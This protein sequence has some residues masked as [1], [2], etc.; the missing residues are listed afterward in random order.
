VK[1]ML[2]QVVFIV[3]SAVL[4]MIAMK[5]HAFEM[6]VEFSAD[7]IQ[8]L[9][10][11]TLNKSKMFVSKTAV[12]TETKQQGRDVVEIN[13]LLTGKKILLDTEK[14]VYREKQGVVMRPAWRDKK[15]RSPC[16]G[17]KGIKCL[18]LGNENL[19]NMVVKKWQVERIINGKKF[20]SM[21]WIESDRRFAIKEMMP[22]G[23]IAELILI[24]SGKLDG[25]E[26]EQWKSIYS[27]PSGQSSETRQWYDKELKMV[28]R[29][30]D[31]NG[32]VR[33]LVNIKVERQSP[34]L[35]MVPQGYKKIK[36]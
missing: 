30:E 35:F 3:F 22:D 18:D 8:S 13:Y 2:R 27:H 5:S 33:E 21:H 10:G 20:K 1:V 6:R 28:T 4:M 31:N 29:E 16:E 34:D 32:H 15:L 17:I 12:R 36:N 11:R 25:R 26:S 23:S 14:S 7:A 19:R 24:G 9:S